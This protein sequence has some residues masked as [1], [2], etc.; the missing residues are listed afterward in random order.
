MI[1]ITGSVT[2]VPETIDELLA[3]GREHVR[4]SRE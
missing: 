3:A 1:I 2:G 4:R